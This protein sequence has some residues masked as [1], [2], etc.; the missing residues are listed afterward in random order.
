M[1]EK[2]DRLPHY[3]DLLDKCRC[4]RAFRNCPLGKDF[5]E[6]LYDWSYHNPL[7]PWL[8][9]K[10]CDPCMLES[11]IGEPKVSGIKE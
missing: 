4:W 8:V 2:S 6:K 1:Q 7:N 10:V 5:L 9:W 3:Q 11:P